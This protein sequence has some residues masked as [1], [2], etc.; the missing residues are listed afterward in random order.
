MLPVAHT[1]PMCKSLKQHQHIYIYSAY[2]FRDL[3]T[4]T[5]IAFKKKN[6]KKKHDPPFEAMMKLFTI[7]AE[8][9][10]HV[11][12]NGHWSWQ[13]VHGH[14]YISAPYDCHAGQGET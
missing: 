10:K 1:L 7:K 3:Y 12:V 8:V 5:D 2:I 13:A 6:I 9:W 4:S 14:G 11:E